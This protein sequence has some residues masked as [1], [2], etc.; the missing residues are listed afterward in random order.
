MAP[1]RRSIFRPQDL[2]SIM[3]AAGHN[4]LTR[5]GHRRSSLIHQENADPFLMLNKLDATSQM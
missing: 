1:P 3:T 5:F 4:G 2:A